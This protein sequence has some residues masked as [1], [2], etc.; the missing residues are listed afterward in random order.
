MENYEHNSVTEVETG[1]LIITRVFDAPRTLVWKAWTDPHYI[2]R[3]HGPKDFTAPFCKIDLR[4]DGT[5]LFCMRSKGGQEFWST[6][7][8]KEIVPLERIVCTDNFADKDGNIVPPS[9]YGISGDWRE[10][11][12]VTITFEDFIDPADSNTNR[13]KM[14]LTHAGL[15]AG[16]MEELTGAGWNESFDKL[17]ES[18]K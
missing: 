10:Q 2:R 13:T 3:W 4:V 1:G 12:L 17:A 16:Q 7:T 18:L 6:G 14:T 15:P 11:L 8:Y 9:Y 5:Y